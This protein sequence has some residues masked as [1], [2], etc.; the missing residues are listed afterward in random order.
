MVL[1][2][3]SMYLIELSPKMEEKFGVKLS[4]SNISRFFDRNDISRKKVITQYLG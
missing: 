2:T 4:E 3:P 1:E